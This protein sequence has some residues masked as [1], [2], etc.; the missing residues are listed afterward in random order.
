MRGVHSNNKKLTTTKKLPCR[1]YTVRYALVLARRAAAPAVPLP[2]TLH[3]QI[4]ELLSDADELQAPSPTASAAPWRR[5]SAFETAQQQEVIKLFRRIANHA[6]LSDCVFDSGLYLG[7]CYLALRSQVHGLVS[8]S[9]EH[10]LLQRWP[11]T[12]AW[13]ALATALVVLWTQLDSSAQECAKQAI[14]ATPISGTFVLC[15][16]FATR[17]IRFT[18]PERA[19]TLFLHLL[20]TCADIRH[21]SKLLHRVTSLLL[22]RKRQNHSLRGASVASAR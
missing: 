12:R 3:T 1:E 13:H 21:M 4:Q 19:A 18:F 17:S 2:G 9:V 7:M 8:D 15:A 10:I 11:E 14:E 20:G 16:W 5:S 6:Y 22:C